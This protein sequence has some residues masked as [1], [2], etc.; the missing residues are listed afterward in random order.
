M[1]TGAIAERFKPMKHVLGDRYRQWLIDRNIAPMPVKALVGLEE[2]QDV[3]LLCSRLVRDLDPKVY[4]QELAFAHE[5]A[6]WNRPFAIS[7]DPSALFDKSVMWFLPNDLVS[8]PLWDYSRQVYEFALGLERQNNRLFCSSDELLHWENK[9]HMHRKLDEIGAPTPRTKLL[10]AENW[11]ETD[12]DIEPVLIKEEHSAGSAGV[13]F[14]AT[15]AEV[16]EF[17]VAHKFKPTETLIMQEVVEGATKDLRVTMVGDKAIESA[18]FWRKKRPEALSSPAWTTTAS[19]Y[20]TLIEHD[21]IPSSAVSLAARY[22][23][24]LGLRTAG[25]D[26]IWVADDESRDPLVLELSPYY[27]PNPPKPE[28][29][30][31][32]TYREFKAREYAQEGYLFEQYRV[33]R[34]I[35]REILEQKLY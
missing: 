5:L 7:A 34:T 32:L 11:E 1:F 9:V 31:D 17:V 6:E 14:F 12:F 28:R 8:P 25:L 10:T 16:R 23:R 30:R 15:A 2:T 13:H 24:M 3:L 27:Q 22:L 26:F 19:K 33:F 4:I 18:T 35:A 21:D 29:Y 20:D